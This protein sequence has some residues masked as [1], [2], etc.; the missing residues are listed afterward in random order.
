MKHQGKIF[1]I[2]LSRTGTQSLAL[3]LQALG[4]HVKHWCMHMADCHNH[5]AT[6][7]IGTAMRFPVLDKLYPGSKFIYTVRDRESWLDSCERWWQEHRALVRIPPVNDAQAIQMEQEHEVYGSWEFD[8]DLWNAV[9]NAHDQRVRTHF[10][11]RPHDILI[12]DIC[13]GEGWEKLLPF[14]GFGEV[15]FPCKNR[16]PLPEESADYLS[17]NMEVYPDGPERGDP[18][19]D[20]GDNGVCELRGSSAPDVAEDDSALHGGGGGDEPGGP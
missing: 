2:G 17:N 15:P 8:R 3:A 13:N 14:L 7:D 12:M 10:E 18:A 11:N 19:G 1:G 20:A 5:D 16:G 9:Y 4:Y 6:L